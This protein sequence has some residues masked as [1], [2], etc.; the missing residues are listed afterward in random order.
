MSASKQLKEFIVD[1]L[2]IQSART[3]DLNLLRE[4]CKNSAPKHIIRIIRGCTRHNIRYELKD[5]P[6]PLREDW[7]DDSRTCLHVAA[8]DGDFEMISILFEKLSDEDKRRLLTLEAKDADTG[9]KVSWLCME[10]NGGVTWAME[11]ANSA[12]H[13]ALKTEIYTEV[14]NYTCQNDDAQILLLLLSTV[15]SDKLM[16]LMSRFKFGVERHSCI[17]RAAWLGNSPFIS[18][19]LLHFPCDSVLPLLLEHCEGDGGRTALH[20]ACEEIELN[21]V[22]TIIDLAFT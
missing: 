7:K 11:L 1:Y 17:Q 20:I 22:K 8:E 14:L 3:P 6:E 19:I 5:I 9:N 13:E 15:T 18:I 21:V 2:K 16:S 4:L 10:W 12:T